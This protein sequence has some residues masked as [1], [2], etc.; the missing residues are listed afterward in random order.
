MH[1]FLSHPQPPLRRPPHEVPG[2]SLRTRSEGVT[3]PGVSPVL[4]PMST[5]SHCRTMIRSG[6]TMASVLG[7]TAGLCLNPL[8]AVDQPLIS[9]DFSQFNKAN[10]LP[11]YVQLEPRAPT[12]KPAETKI[13][14]IPDPDDAH[15]LVAR[16]TLLPGE[17]RE[18]FYFMRPGGTSGSLKYGP[19]GPNEPNEE[20]WV[21]FRMR[22]DHLLDPQLPGG[23]AC[24]FQLGPVSNA[25]SGEGKGLFQIMLSRTGGNLTLRTFSSSD[26]ILGTRIPENSP[27]PDTKNL[28]SNPEGRWIAFTC[29]LRLRT[30]ADGFLR[31]WADGNLV[32][33]LHGAN[34]LL[35]DQIR[36]KWGTYI[37]GGNAYRDT[38]SADYDDIVIDEK[39][40]GTDDGFRTSAV[41]IPTPYTPGVAFQRTLVPPAGLATTGLTLATSPLPAGITLNAA[42]RT[43]SGTLAS[44]AHGQRI[45]W[46]LADRSGVR[47]YQQV[48][49]LSDTTAVA[50]APSLPAPAAPI[51]DIATSTTPTLSGTTSV[52][53][54]VRIYDGSTL[55]GNVLSGNTGKWS[56]RVSPALLEGNHDLRITVTDDANTTSPF[57]M[58]T[59]VVVPDTTP[60]RRPTAPTTSSKTSPTPALS[61]ITEPHATVTL[62]D[63]ADVVTTLVANANGNWWWRVPSAL[64]LG[65]HL[66]KCTA[67]DASG[68][69]SQASP[70][71][72]V[73]VPDRTAPTTPAAPSSDSLTSAAPTLSGIA[74][75]GATV[76]IYDQSTLL[77][78]VIAGVDNTWSWTVS[79][80]L[81]EGTH[82]LAVTVTDTAKNRSAVS[83]VRTI[84]VADTTTPTTP[85][86]PGTNNR[87][88]AKPVLFGTTEAN[89]TVSVLANNTPLATVT[90]GPTGAWAWVATSA[91]AP[92]TYVMTVT[93][94]DAAQHRS[95]ESL[96]TTITVRSAA[97]TDTLPPDTPAA[98]TVSGTAPSHI[99]TGKTEPNANIRVFDNGSLLKSFN[100]N[101]TGDWSWTVN[102]A[103]GLG[104]HVLTVIA[105]DTSG[106]P[107]APSAAVTVTVA[108]T[109]APR[110]PSTPLVNN[111][112]DDRPIVSG[113]T[114]AGAIVTIADNGNI[115]HTLTASRVGTWAW[116]V[117][118]TLRAGVHSLTVTATDAAGNASSPS[119]PRVVTVPDF[120]PPAKPA[121]P[122]VNNLTSATP[123]LSGSAEANATVS[124][125][126][127]IALLGSVVADAAGH[128]SW[129]VSPGLDQGRHALNVTATDAAGNS[130]AR[131][132]PDVILQVPD[133]TPP[134]APTW[135]PTLISTSDPTPALKGS[136]EA[137][138][139]V[140]IYDNGVERF[141][142]IADWR[143]DW[144]WTVAPALPPGTHRLTAKATDLANLVSAPSLPFTI[145]IPGA[146]ARASA[147]AISPSDLTSS[148]PLVRDTTVTTP[149]APGADSSSSATTATDTTI[150]SATNSDS[151]RGGGCGTGGS[152]AMLIG[153]LCA[154]RG[155][156]R[157]P[158]HRRTVAD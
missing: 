19:K 148:S 83:G 112:T 18:E 29:Q 70:L 143:G 138:A 98:P 110:Q 97:V 124:I 10:A 41:P 154:L 25:A 155:L 80:P 92:N 111:P 99:I 37:G 142:V 1:H 24:L 17:D 61:G 78:S 57:S 136:A 20:L 116:R 95:A 158:R 55:I 119:A 87:F 149:V 9:C 130:S 49:C 79:P 74:E 44:S 144:A 62:Y 27:Y 108:D 47:R 132:A 66:F 122:S 65:T 102:P 35:E 133:T 90:A 59:T 123:S 68:N 4:R 128:W 150:P 139:R 6:V 43:I 89:A 121:K 93:A 5:P 114:E 88:S 100:A 51:V 76:A 77:T 56:W 48:L 52:F 32:A 42:T 58:V 145:T 152:V 34:A 45:A 3:I 15:N 21:G 22:V 135:S 104:S 36:V 53:A 146:A 50:P 94:T 115:L 26:S 137:F 39:L 46:W 157:T 71:T 127:D 134:N 120:T 73:T 105:T 151:N 106:N 60:P 117:S 85:A 13:A 54:T 113:T 140:T 12:E 96:A 63:G 156:R 38:L 33:D 81:A 72:S 84:T 67:T 91:L 8:M 107:S 23:N 109:T 75:A 30:T 69:T 14:F 118:P 126:D 129:T 101:A 31:V 40:L 153:G 16:M 11:P 28:V 103:L 141:T 82:L 86:A 125:Y 7:M 147:A 2:I 64:S 131:S